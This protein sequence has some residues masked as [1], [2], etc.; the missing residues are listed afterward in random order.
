MSDSRSPV[1]RAKRNGD[2]PARTE[3]WGAT[4]IRVGAGDAMQVLAL[5]ALRRVVRALRL[6]A[7]ETERVAGLTA[8]QLFVL[9]RAT[10]NPGQSLT[11]LARQTLTD[12][13]SVAAVVERLV[14]RRLVR[15]HCSARDQR[16][17]E[18]YPTRRGADT[19]ARAPHPPTIRVLE[20]M[21]K[22]SPRDLQS[23]AVGL[24]KLADAMGLASEPAAMLFD[25]P[26]GQR[27][28][29]SRLAAS[30]GKTRRRDV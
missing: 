26:L 22:I 16:R 29:T 10:S 11:E 28:R 13:T 8:A 5:D 30:P 24:T 3:R 18:I 20:A 7:S 15:R 21:A 23:L 2:R 27:A 25:E 17:V 6:A 1:P 12:R 14:K 19:V 9:A 4:S